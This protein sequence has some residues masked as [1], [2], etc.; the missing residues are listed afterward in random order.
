VPAPPRLRKQQAE[1]R[2]SAVLE[3]AD[4]RTEDLNAL[5]G[6]DPRELLLAAMLWR[7]TTVSQEWPTDRLAMRS[8][9]NVSQRCADLIA[10]APAT[11]SQTLRDFQTQADNIGV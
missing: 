7:R 11:V 6:S 2:L 9:A 5:K 4:L 1:E 8:A 3:A 10:A